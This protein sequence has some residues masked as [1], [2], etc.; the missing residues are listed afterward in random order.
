MI[1]GAVLG[2]RTVFLLPKTASASFG[3]SGRYRRLPPCT[4][5]RNYVSHLGTWNVRGINGNA[6]REEVVDIFKKGKYE[7]LALT[8]T[9]LKAKGGVSWC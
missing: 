8:E 7:M 3:R 4:T 6:K 9:K 2:A 1:W 5:R